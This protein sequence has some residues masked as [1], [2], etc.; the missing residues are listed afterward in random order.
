[1]DISPCQSAFAKQEDGAAPLL[2]GIAL[3]LIHVCAYNIWIYVTPPQAMR[4]YSKGCLSLKFTA[5]CHLSIACCLCHPS[6]QSICILYP[7]PHSTGTLHSLR[8]QNRYC[9]KIFLKSMKFVH[10]QS[11]HEVVYILRSHRR[12]SKRNENMPMFQY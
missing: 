10:T 3:K 4:P 12:W 2:L 7:L 9:H 1:M 6:M 11:L 5:S 8:S